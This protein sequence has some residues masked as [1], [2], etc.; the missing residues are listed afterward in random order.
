MQGYIKD[1]RQ[2]L[3]SDVWEMPPLYHRIWQWLKYTVNHSDNEIP[4]R[5][6]TRLLI[7][8]GQHL[9]SIRDI[10]REVGW[11]EGRKKKEPN[12][13]TVMS[14]LNWLE[15][16]NMIKLERGQGNRQYTLVTLVKY[17]DFQSFDGQGN[18]K[19]TADGT[20][21]E[22]SVDIN[23]N[24]NNE[25]KNVKEIIDSIFA[26]WKSKNL[27]QHRTITPHI[28]NQIKWKLGHYSANELIHC[29]ST[30]DD[31]LNNPNY[32]LETKWSLNDFLEK[33]HFEK[34]LPDRDP[35]SFYPKVKKEVAPVAPPPQRKSKHV[36]NRER[37]MGGGS[38]SNGSGASE[39]YPVQSIGS[40]PES[41]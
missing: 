22:Q 4:M 23:N 34:F 8:R 20:G 17:D 40:L 36:K 11:Y 13:K 27:I 18:A 24:D 5:D 41:T 35:Y 10:A 3:R 30:Y 19:V 26:H 7:K 9:T 37:L 6:G 14:V 2:E 21:R 32:K 31:I 33:G 16:S 29:I 39:V 25:L 15:K 12:P 38:S 1:H 28:I